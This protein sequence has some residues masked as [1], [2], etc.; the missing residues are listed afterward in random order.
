[1]RTVSAA[2]PAASPGTLRS[3]P[4]PADRG[5]R[6]G[7]SGPRPRWGA[8][9]A[10]TA[11][12]AFCHHRRW[13]APGSPLPRSG[14]SSTWRACRRRGSGRRGEELAQPPQHRRC[15]QPKVEADVGIVIVDRDFRRCWRAQVGHGADDTAT[16][17]FSAGHRRGHHAV[18][19]LAAD[20]ERDGLDAEPVRP[21][22]AAGRDHR[23]VASPVETHPHGASHGDPQQ[24]R[25]PAPPPGDRLPSALAAVGIAA[26]VI[27]GFGHAACARRWPTSP[28]SR[29]SR[30]NATLSPPAPA[31]YG[32]EIPLDR[33]RADRHHGSA[34]GGGGDRRAPISVRRTARGRGRVHLHVGIR[35]EW[36]STAMPCSWTDRLVLAE[37]DDYTPARSPS[38]SAQAHARWPATSG[39]A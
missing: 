34:D 20:V 36:P 35:P 10:A 29:P 26:C 39:S 30:W 6:C 27:D 4:A 21:R 1:M 24:R 8:A 22:R 38:I 2:A 17:S 13:R 31:R 14:L 32:H 18:I 28:G 5:A 3:A 33:R 15:R 37:H 7:L 25:R 23:A 16:R 12:D 11:R 19:V 9:D